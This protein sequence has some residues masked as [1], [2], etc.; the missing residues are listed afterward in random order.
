MQKQKQEQQPITTSKVIGVPT[1]RI[2]GPLKTTGSA[3]YTS[4]HQFPGLVY[5][6]P[7]TATVSSG[8]V[9]K[10]DS[11]AARK[12]TGVLAIYTHEDIG[13]LYRTPPPSGFTLIQDERR[14]PLEDTR[15]SYYGQYVAVAVA[16]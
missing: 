7:V 15:V 1:P 9:G 8:T 13:P 10:I 16:G 11:A 5:A 4:D 12:M 14:P 3:I 2:D 6:W